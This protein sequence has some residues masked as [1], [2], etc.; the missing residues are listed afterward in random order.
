MKDLVKQYQGL[1]QVVWVVPRSSRHLD[2]NEVSEG[3]GGKADIS[4]WH[5]IID[6]AGSSVSSELPVSDSGSRAPNVIIAS[7]TG[8]K[9]NEYEIVE[10][11]QTVCLFRSWLGSL[12]SNAKRSP[13]ESRLSN[14][15]SIGLPFSLSPALPQR[16]T[17]PFGP[18]HQ[19]LPIGPNL[20][21]PLLQQHPSSHRGH[22]SHCKLYFRLPWRLSIRHCR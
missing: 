9:V 18:T 19:G 2:W 7:E 11:T 4:T 5:D 3:E 14:R 21:R 15:S 6:E 8:D 13:P 12:C 16:H 17:P 1:N 10:F 20:H 22:G